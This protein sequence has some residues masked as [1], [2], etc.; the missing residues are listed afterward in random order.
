[1]QSIF[2]PF[3]ASMTIRWPSHMW[4]PHERGMLQEMFM[5]WIHIM[6][7][8]WVLNTS[9]LDYYLEMNATSNPMLLTPSTSSN[10]LKHH[11]M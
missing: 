3:Q 7:G 9:N 6:S 2:L 10:Q 5:F 8:T 11:H 4:F 1:M